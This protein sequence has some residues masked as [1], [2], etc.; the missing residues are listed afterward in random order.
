[1]YC[2]DRATTGVEDRQTSV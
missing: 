2:D 1:M